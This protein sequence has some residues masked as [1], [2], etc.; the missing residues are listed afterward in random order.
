MRRRT[1]VIVVVAIIAGAIIAAASL[2]IYFIRE[3]SGGDVLWSANDAYVFIGVS[4]RG[5]RV[6]YLEYPWAILRGYLHSV[7]LPDDDLGSLIVIRVT[8]SATERHVVDL[9][10]RAPG[11]GPGLYTPFEGR[12]YANYPAL[13][14]LCRWSDDHFERATEDES[15]RL[16][17]S[18]FPDVKGWSNR[19]FGLTAW[20]L[21]N[22]N[23][24]SKR[25][26]GSGP[27]NFARI[28]VDVGGRFTLS[29]KSDAVD[30]TGYASVSIYLQRPGQAPERIWYLDGH[31][32]R[33]SRVEYD[34]M[35]GSH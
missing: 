18:N 10:D 7:R 32:R 13:G 35:F 28:T 5:F 25:G 33:I 3:D 31:P 9:K 15:R 2:R 6:S 17:S 24:W 19:I 27:E 30:S 23:G 11:S 1:K 16:V 29:E 8:P 20:P 22:V 12:I 34:R 14:G 21:D 26:I 4:R